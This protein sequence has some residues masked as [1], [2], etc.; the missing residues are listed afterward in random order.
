MFD[1]RIKRQYTSESVI[2]SRILSSANEGLIK[3][4]KI[5]H[6]AVVDEAPVS[7]GPFDKDKGGLLKNS[8]CYVYRDNSGSFHVD[9]VNSKSSFYRHTVNKNYIDDA[10]AYINI[11]NTSS[12][13]QGVVSTW[14]SR[15]YDAHP[16]VYKLG[17]LVKNIKYEEG[18]NRYNENEVETSEYVHDDDMIGEKTKRAEDTT[19]Y[20][21]YVEYGANGNTPRPFYRVAITRVRDEIDKNMIESLKLERNL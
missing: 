13:V 10:D 16:E 9:G 12:K 1:V 20:A 18:M 2:S 21:P 3:S 11:N 17:P 5:L 4:L 8:I 7:G 14:V 6:A 15:A 19:M